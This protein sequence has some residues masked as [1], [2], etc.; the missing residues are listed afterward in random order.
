LGD[1]FEKEIRKFGQFAFRSKH[2]SGE[3]PKKFIDE[4][5]RIREEERRE[6]ETQEEEGRT[7]CE[8]TNIFRDP[9][10]KIHAKKLGSLGKPKSA[11]FSARNLPGTFIQPF[12]VRSSW[13]LALG[14]EGFSPGGGGEGARVSG[15]ERG[16]P[17]GWLA[18]QEGD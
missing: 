13:C 8:K 15:E 16:D 3:A 9:H 11:H 12:L 7:G 4:F 2:S 18:E 14:V 6:E 10:G 5:I 1:V 17:A